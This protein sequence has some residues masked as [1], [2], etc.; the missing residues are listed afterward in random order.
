MDLTIQQSKKGCLDRGIFWKKSYMWVDSY[1][2]IFLLRGEVGKRNF[3]YWG[4]K[5]S[6]GTDVWNNFLSLGT[7]KSLRWLGW[8]WHIK[9]LGWAGKYDLIL[10][11]FPCYVVVL[12]FLLKGF[13]NDEGFWAGT[14]IRQSNYRIHQPWHKVSWLLRKHKSLHGV[15]GGEDPYFFSITVSPLI[16]YF[17]FF[18]TVSK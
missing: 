1:A 12:S 4:S 14:M 8:A 18:R 7:L 2:E 5:V 9:T 6:K 13:G 11:A 15:G 10:G 17:N 3:P 16:Q